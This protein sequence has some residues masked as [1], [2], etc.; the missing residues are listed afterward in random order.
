MFAVVGVAVVMPMIMAVVVPIRHPGV[1]A[2]RES[3]AQRAERREVAHGRVPHPP[4]SMREKM[5]F[6]DCQTMPTI[7]MVMT[8]PMNDH[9]IAH[10]VLG[11]G[12]ARVHADRT[13]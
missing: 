7:T 6:A 3:E 8:S 4:S 12:N 9:L 2:V 13:S 5:A 10:A 1:V 11:S